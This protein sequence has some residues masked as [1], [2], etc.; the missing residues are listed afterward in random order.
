MSFLAFYEHRA[1]YF[2]TL[3]SYTPM[4]KG[5]GK[6]YFKNC[7]IMVSQPWPFSQMG[8]GWDLALDFLTSR[9][10]SCGI[11]FWKAKCLLGVWL[12][13]KNSL[14]WWLGEMEEMVSVTGNLKDWSLEGQA[15]GRKGLAFMR[16]ESIS[17]THSWALSQILNFLE[18]SEVYK[19]RYL[20]LWLRD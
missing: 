14:S 20:T 16:T 13:Q 11:S 12:C 18:Y 19:S 15:I 2:C 10:W 8:W 4:K 6:C 9:G 3:D 7:K 17:K 1:S 5:V